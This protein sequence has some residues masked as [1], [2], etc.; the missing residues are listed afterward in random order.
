M[1]STTRNVAFSI[2]EE[3]LDY[4]RIT[5]INLQAMNQP[6]GAGKD[7]EVLTRVL[8]GIE[9]CRQRLSDC[10]SEQAEK[11]A[12]LNQ[13]QEHAI[14]CGRITLEVQDRLYLLT[15]VEQYAVE[16]REAL[17]AITDHFASVMRG[18]LIAGRVTFVNGIEAIPTIARARRTLAKFNGAAGGC[19]TDHNALP[20][21]ERGAPFES[22]SRGDQDAASGPTPASVLTGLKQPTTTKE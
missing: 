5:A 15:N 9:E 18:P 11:N 22:A 1:T 4:L 8:L 3:D 2:R 17:E 7:A 10:L 12:M 13:A 21:S 6:D 16:M 14:D 20:G 19:G